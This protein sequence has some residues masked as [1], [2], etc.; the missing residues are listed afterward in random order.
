MQ[1]NLLDFYEPL[2]NSIKK[3]HY[4]SLSDLSLTHD[5]LSEIKKRLFLHYSNEV[6][7]EALESGKW[8]YDLE[9]PERRLVFNPQHHLYHYHV[10]RVPQ[11][12]ELV[13][14][15]LPKTDLLRVEVNQLF[16]N[17]GQ[18]KR[19]TITYVTKQAVRSD[20]AKLCYFS[21][22]IN[23]LIFFWMFD[24]F[25]DSGNVFVEAMRHISYFFYRLTTILFQ[26]TTMGIIQVT[27]PPF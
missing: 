27:D 22:F 23:L 17:T 4:L 15:E 6:L 21:L 8:M 5:V 9:W 12:E 10:L 19:N 18:H 7:C 13:W 24:V 16:Y 20:Y 26:I 11:D 2:W 14:F 25:R 1:S 3:I